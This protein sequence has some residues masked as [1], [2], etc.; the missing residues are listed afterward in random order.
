MTILD[1]QVWWEAVLTKDARMDGVFYYAVTSTGVYCRPSCPSRLPR[2]ANVLFFPE[3]DAAEQ[4]GYRACRRCTPRADLLAPIKRAGRYI[5]QHLD[6]RLTLQDLAA[7]A[8][9]SPSY[10]QRKFKAAFGLSPHEYAEACRT[11]QLKSELRNGAA[12]T[13]AI[14]GAGY[15]SSSRV[16]ER[17]DARIGMTPA[18]YRSGGRGTRIDYAVA[19]SPLGRMLVAA[20]GRGVCAIR[21]GDAD[22]EL[23]AGLRAEFPA[24]E[25]RRNKAAVR[26]WIEALL[27]HLRGPEIP[28]E[29]PLDI[30]ATAFQK[31]VWDHLRG[32][33]AGKTE[34]Y[35]EVAEAIGEP[36]AVRAVAGACAANPVA[37]AIPCH[38][39]VRSDG[40][41]GGYRWGAERKELLLG[42]ERGS[43][44]DRISID[45]AVGGRSPR[46]L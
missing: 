33:P 12:V 17:S 23:E 16:Y 10:F 1:E 29:L 8:G 24:A 22:A 2:R 44:G 31:K 7:R 4:A 21:F 46:S 25:I 13:D 5:E 18:A 28:L 20:T 3:A 9:L 30:R 6:E 35:R 36:R 34:S 32:I 27:H 15:G 14:Y 26:R 40:E 11:R 43:K 45:A 41:A 37:V 42:R 19:E 38:R 39:V